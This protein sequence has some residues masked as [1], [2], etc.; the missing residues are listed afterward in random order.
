MT[1]KVKDMF[2]EIIKLGRE[3]GV[4]TYEDINELL[5]TDDFF[6]PDDLED[7]M[8]TLEAMGIKVLETSEN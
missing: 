6:S 2:N 3:R 7:L 8:D 4:L 5:P 1:K